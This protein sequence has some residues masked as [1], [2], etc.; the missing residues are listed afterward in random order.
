M[1]VFIMIIIYRVPMLKYGLQGGGGSSET[2]NDWRD[3]TCLEFD[4][5]PDPFQGS[6]GIYVKHT[7][8]EIRHGGKCGSSAGPCAY[9][10]FGRALLEMP[11]FAWNDFDRLSMSFWFRRSSTNGLKTLVNKYPEGEC[12]GSTFDVG[13]KNRREMKVKVMDNQLGM[14]TSLIGVSFLANTPDILPGASL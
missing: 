3:I 11:Y 1:C 4:A 2:V 13:T 10:P 14:F 6:K 8:V 7:G 9:F 12:S 5:S